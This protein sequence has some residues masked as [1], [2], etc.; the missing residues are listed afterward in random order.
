MENTMPSSSIKLDLRPLAYTAAQPGYFAIHPDT[1]RVPIVAWTHWTIGDGQ[2]WPITLMGR[3]P[4][5]A[6]VLLPDGR[7]WDI[8][9]DG[10]Y[11]N[12]AEW[13][14]GWA[15]RQRPEADDFAAYAHR[16]SHGGDC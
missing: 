9:V 12:E 6:G 5:G 3:P 7:V 10:F 16:H 2:P 13:L 15:S 1:T 4:E 14:R 8:G 11:V